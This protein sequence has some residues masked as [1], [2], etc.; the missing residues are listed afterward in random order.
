M[1]DI[2]PYTISVPDAK[3]QRLKQQLEV[4]DFPQYEIPNAGWKYG[5][6]V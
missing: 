5:T 4:T 2:K 1:P 3:L 6:P